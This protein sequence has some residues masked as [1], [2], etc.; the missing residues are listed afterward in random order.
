M[1]KFYFSLLILVV[2]VILITGFL[3]LAK[4]NGLRETFNVLASIKDA[5]QNLFSSNYIPARQEVATPIVKKEDLEEETI[6]KEK[7]EENSDFEQPSPLDEIVEKI[8]EISEKVD[9]LAQ[10]VESF[11]EEQ[12]KVENVEK[13]EEIEEEA[14]KIEE[15]EEFEEEKEGIKEQNVPG[16]EIILCQRANQ[17]PTQDKVIFNEIS[18]MGT[19]L[20]WRNEWFELKNFSGNDIALKGWQVL[21]K[22]QEIK[23]IFEEKDNILPGQLFLLERTNDDSVPNILADKLYSGNLNDTDEVLY[24]FDENCQLRDEVIANPSWPA[25]DKTER[26]SMERNFDF[27]WY[28][29]SGSVDNGILGTPK[30]ENSPKF[31]S[32]GGAAPPAA[33][34]PT[35]LPPKILINEIQISPLEERFI[36]LYNPSENEV[37]L[38]GWYI[39]RKTPTGTSWISLV[40]STNFEGKKIM[41]KSYFLISRV[42]I[43]NFD[44]I[45]EDLTLTEDNVILL[46]DSSREVAD[47]VGWGQAQDFETAPAENPLSGKSL[48]RKW[49]EEEEEYQDIDNNQEDFEIQNPTPKEKN[50]NFVPPPSPVV[51]DNI[52]PQVSFDS[53]SSLQTETSFLLSWLGQDFAP[54]N[55]IP[56]GLDGFY[57]QY[58]VTPSDIDGIAIQ[59]QDK[60]N[61]WQEWGLGQI[62]ELEENQNSINLLGKE[63][64]I[65]SFQIKAK[66]KSGNESD[67]VEII[68]EINTLPVVINEIAWMGTSIS[69]NNEWIEIFNNTNQTINL[70]DWILKATDGIPEI[71]LEG[72]ILAKGLYLLERTDDNTIPEIR[73]DQIYTGALGNSGEDLKIFDNSGKLIDS[74]AC[75]EDW[76]AG[77]NK[78]KQTMERKNPLLSGNNSENWATSQN[79]GGTPKNQNSQYLQ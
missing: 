64:K 7:F 19:N 8:D 74:V 41:P 45:L 14:E 15:I 59:Y 68:I 40:S 75:G 11:I 24:L 60:D 43:E 27:S 37:N 73:A 42:S 12:G 58:N 25:G 69:F 39:Q 10:E 61:G 77:D 6:E 51:E 35:T 33:S 26:R 4:N 3:I 13:V 16:K 28:T 36:E 29:F 54:D 46:K 47:K 56:S 32:A 31:T 78:T 18:W 17:S 79:P 57:L 49:L 50:Q 5:F 76:F 22:E 67:W 62:L 66:D 1:S 44:I 2:S 52:P 48:G 23:I 63:D 70:T 9:L 34:E 53:V 71:R 72:E 65:Y 30:A 20:D 55:V 21:D 38:T